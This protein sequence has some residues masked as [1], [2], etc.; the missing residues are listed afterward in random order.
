M[1]WLPR[2]GVFNCFTVVRNDWLLHPTMAKLLAFIGLGQAGVHNQKGMTDR[3]I[4]AWLKA[5]MSVQL[6][7]CDRL[8]N[9]GEAQ[10]RQESSVMV[11]GGWYSKQ[12]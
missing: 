10:G 11:I 12:A 6:K 9:H 7:W 5:G 3:L 2:L 1:L 8:T 4:T